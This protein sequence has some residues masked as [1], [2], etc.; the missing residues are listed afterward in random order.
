MKEVMLAWLAD[1]GYWAWNISLTLFVLVN[2]AAI[3]V[4]VATRDTRLVQRWTGRW[5]AFNLGLIGL[6]LG[7]PLVTGIVR[8]ALNALPAFGSASV[9]EPK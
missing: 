2:A 8:F 9:I 1:A 3:V 5:L 6:G 4:M 7:T